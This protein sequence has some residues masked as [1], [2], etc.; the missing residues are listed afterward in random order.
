[1]RRYI[2]P[3]LFVLVLAT[4][5]VVR[6][7]I[8]D[9]TERPSSGELR[10]VVITPHGEPIRREF[11]DAF[12]EWHR[13]RFGKTVVVDYRNF[14]GGASDIVKY[15]NATS[16]SGYFQKTGTYGVDVAWGGGETLFSVDLKKHLLPVKLSPEVMSTAYPKPDIGGVALY[17]K[18]GNWFGTTLGSFGIVYN[19]DVL[20]YLGLPEPKTW[21]DLTDPRYRNYI[22]L[23]DPTRSSSARTAFMAIVE[24]QMAIAKEAAGADDKGAEDRGWA[25]GMGLIRQIAANA[26]VF[27]DASSSVP[28]V[29][30]SGDAAAGMAIDFYG[31][32][33]VEM[34]G[35]SRVGYVEPAEATIVNPDPIAVVKGTQNKEL[36]IR[37]IEFIL[38]TEGQRLWNYRV[39]APGGPKQTT[40][41][42]LPIVPS[43]YA[44]QTYFTDKVNPFLIA[45]TF[46]TR[47][48]RTG[49]FKTL[50]DQ[51]QVSCI[52]VLAE[53]RETR[54]LIL[55]SPAAVEL[56]KKLGTFPFDQKEALA[57]QK[58][59]NAAKPLQRLELIRGWE[60]EFKAEYK[61]LREQVK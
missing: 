13:A 17:D 53:L 49:T 12:S 16:D 37:F 35:E 42:R 25:R 24:K 36:A 54:K 10:L 27:T 18:D 28:S 19:K 52:D 2:F 50:G 39:G 46:N 14:G 38:S 7:I 8:G 21:E 47:R 61:A 15:F 3:I 20:R 48:E 56:D 9:A 33:Q 45:G 43:V 4:P 51:I 30:G 6:A 26:R 59:L 41:R 5:F 34:S 32:T 44:D 29:V 31:R 58:T 11:G 55:A 22:I 1:M 23:A 60:Q 57:R 40:L